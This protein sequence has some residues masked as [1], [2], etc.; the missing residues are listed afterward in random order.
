L[1]L[2]GFADGFAVGGDGHVD[3]RAGQLRQHIHIAH[4]KRA[5]RLHDH[6]HAVLRRKLGQQRARQ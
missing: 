1:W 5:A 3:A 4:D 6:A 2:K